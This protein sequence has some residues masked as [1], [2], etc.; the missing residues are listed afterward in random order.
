MTCATVSVVV[1]VAGERRVATGLCP[2]PSWVMQSISVAILFAWIQMMLIVGRFPTWGHYALMFSTVL[3]N[4]SKVSYPSFV[5]KSVTEEFSIFYNFVF[6]VLLAFVWLIVGFALSFSVLF[7]GND[8]FSDSWKSFVKTVVMIM[9]EYD[10]DGLF[11]SIDNQS[12]SN[13]IKNQ[14]N[15]TNGSSVRENSNHDFLPVISRIIFLIFVMLASIVLMNLLIGLAVSDIQGLL[16]EVRILKSTSAI[17]IFFFFFTVEVNDLTIMVSSWSGTHSSID[18]TGCLRGAP[19]MGAITQDAPR[20][21]HA[22]MSEV[23]EFGSDWNNTG[24]VYW[25]WTRNPR[26]L[27]GVGGGPFWTGCEESGD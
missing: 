26:D 24:H 22:K 2:N 6:Q 19:G 25:L 10:Y 3:K 11:A 17:S 4:V 5:T 23:K 21:F 27:R 8:Q 12:Y 7:H 1:A 13:L 9:G 14:I 15:D 20:T 18:E 16:N